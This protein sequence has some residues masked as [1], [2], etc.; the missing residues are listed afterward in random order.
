MIVFLPASL[1]SLDGL[2]NLNGEEMLRRGG[3]AH[4]VG[5]DASD[6]ELGSYGQGYS[7]VLEML[8]LR[9]IVA[10]RWTGTRD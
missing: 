9:V 6:W 10:P 1:A 5:T 4:S 3:D 8:I 2:P 7:D